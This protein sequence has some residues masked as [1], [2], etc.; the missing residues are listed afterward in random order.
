MYFVCEIWMT[1]R[2]PLQ[3][4]S[5]FNRYWYYTELVLA[6]ASAVM[7]NSLMTVCNKNEKPATIAVVGQ[8]AIGYSFLSD[9]VFFGTEFEPIQYIGM[10][11][12][13]SFSVGTGIYKMNV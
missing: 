2:Y 6:A 4:P 5:E 12:T 11:V 3:A 8:S 9:N 7:A 13:L 10:L 1:G